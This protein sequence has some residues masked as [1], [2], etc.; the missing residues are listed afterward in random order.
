MKGLDLDIVFRVLISCS[1]CGVFAKGNE[2]LFIV[3]V[4]DDVGDQVVSIKSKFVFTIARC[5][6][7]MEEEQVPVEELKSYSFTLVD[8]DVIEVNKVTS[9]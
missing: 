3:Q 9:S 7:I 8:I 2:L 6:V 5:L 1:V 4:E